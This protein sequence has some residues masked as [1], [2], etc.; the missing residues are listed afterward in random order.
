MYRPWTDKLV[1]VSIGLTLLLLLAAAE[2]VCPWICIPPDQ[3]PA[4]APTNE[5][6]APLDKPE[7]S[8]TT[9]EPLSLTV[10]LPD[11]VPFRWSRQIKRATLAAS[12]GAH[13]G[14]VAYGPLLT[15]NGQSSG[16]QA[17]PVPVAPWLIKSNRPVRSITPV[18]VVDVPVRNPAL[19]TV[20]LRTGPPMV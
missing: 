12:I 18:L 16:L 5:N 9:S 10:V 14:T 15:V 20:L 13:Q 17:L 2:K 6:Q 7:Q 1:R 8:E 3:T 19:T 11:A 4:E